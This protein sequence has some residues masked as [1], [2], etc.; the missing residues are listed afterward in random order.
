MNREQENMLH[1]NQLRF[2][3]RLC[4]RFRSSYRQKEARAAK[5][6]VRKGRSANQEIPR[7]SWKPKVHCRV[8]STPLFGPNVSQIN[9]AHTL[10]PYCFMTFLSIHTPA[11]DNMFQVVSTLP[12]VHQISVCIFQSS[13]ACLIQT[14]LFYNL[15]DI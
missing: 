2:V 5:S 3:K 12:I 1:E 14:T 11:Y 10:L 4:F 15:N 9:P 7:F 13:H 6:F 8:H